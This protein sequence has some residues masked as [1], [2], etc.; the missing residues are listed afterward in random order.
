[1][2]SKEVDFQNWKRRKNYDPMKAAKDGR[3]KQLEKTGPENSTSGNV[4]S[5]DRGSPR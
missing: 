4:T 2:S 5:S 1:M 3:K